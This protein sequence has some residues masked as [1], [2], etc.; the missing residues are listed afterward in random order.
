MVIHDVL[1][2]GRGEQGGNTGGYGWKGQ[3]PALDALYAHG[4]LGR[5][6]IKRVVRLQQQLQREGA[7]RCELVRRSVERVSAIEDGGI[8]LGY[9]KPG[10]WQEP[11][12]RQSRARV[13]R[14]ALGERKLSQ[15][16]AASGGM[17]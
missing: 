5:I 3:G 7:I 6:L 10:W 2:G 14:E 17:V 9:E 13:R 12:I 8:G 1:R 4:L 11:N 15:S 16:D